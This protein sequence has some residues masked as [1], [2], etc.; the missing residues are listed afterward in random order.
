MVGTKEAVKATQEAVE[1]TKEAAKESKE[2]VTSCCFE[3]AGTTEQSEVGVAG[4]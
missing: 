3:P 1:V 4:C 2:G